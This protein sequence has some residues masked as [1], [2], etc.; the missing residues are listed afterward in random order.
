MNKS[1]VRANLL[2]ENSAFV[3]ARPRQNKPQKP[4]QQQQQQNLQFVN[5]PLAQHPTYQQDEYYQQQQREQ[6]H[7]HQQ[8][9]Q[10]H[11]NQQAP[12][13][14][15]Q[16]YPV[17]QNY[18]NNGY[19]NQGPPPQQRSHT[20]YP[21]SN[22]PTYEANSNNHP[23]QYMDKQRGS[24]S[25]PYQQNYD[26]QP[27][28]APPPQQQRSQSYQYESPQNP[29]EK[30]Q[31]HDKR[32]VSHTYSQN[33]SQYHHSHPHPHQQAPPLQPLKPK[34][35]IFLMNDDS[36]DNVNGKVVHVSK[37]ADVS[38]DNDKIQQL[39][40]KI[41]RLERVLALQQDISERSRS[42]SPNNS[43]G[44]AR[45]V[46]SPT[47]LGDDSMGTLNNS[48]NSIIS[49]DSPNNGNA[50]PLPPPPPAE[51]KSLSSSPKAS[52]FK[53]EI[54]IREQQQQQQQ[55]Q[56]QGTSDNSSDLRLSRTSLIPTEKSINEENDDDE[57]DEDD[58]DYNN[59][60]P[61][62]S[63]EELEKSGSLTY[64][65]SIY[66]TPY[67]KAGYQL[68][69]NKTPTNT[70]SDE[71]STLKQLSELEVSE[72]TSNF[73][74][75][76]TKKSNL[77]MSK[78]K[79]PT[80][81]NESEESEVST[82]PIPIPV[83]ISVPV[84][85]PAP[86]QSQQ[87][88]VPPKL[89]SKQTS[90]STSTLKGLNQTKS[91]TLD[92]LYTNNNTLYHA[93]N[94]N[95]NSTNSVE[96]IEFIKYVD[97]DSYETLSNGIIKPILPSK[98][99][100]QVEDTISKF[101]KTRERAIADYKQF[102][103]KI[104]FYWAILLLETLSKTEVI[105]KMTIDG[106]VRKNPLNF[107]KLKKQRMM[108]LT[109]AIKV[110]EKL[111]QIA[112]N[113]TRARLYLGDIY[114]GGI[115]P[116]FIERDEKLGYKL[117]YE[118]AI[119]QNDPIAY[120]RVGCCLDSG[121][122]TKQDI[123]KSIMFFEKGALLGDPSCMTQ[124]GWMYL[125]GLN[126]C[127]QDI[128][129][130]ISYYKQSYETLR[131]KTIMCGD[132]LITARSFE[133]AKCSFFTL[134]KLYQ[135]DKTSFN[136]INLNDEKVI[137]TIENLKVSNVWRNKSKSLKYY[138]ESAKLGDERSQACLGYYYA[139]GF[140]PTNEFKS[141]KES[142]NGVADSIDARKSIYWFSKSAANGHPY[143]SLG[144]A[145][146]YGSG[147]IDSNGKIILKR[148]EQQAFLWGRKAADTGELSEAEF[149]IGVCFEQGFGV[150]KNLIMAE[151]Y[152]KRSSLHGYK[153]ATSKLKRSG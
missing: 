100:V 58:G 133:D 95:S 51:M 5:H 149:M 64:S 39:E 54:E 137:E 138:L 78:R 150:E 4:S 73:P 82:P 9:P 50:P 109:T 127:I 55:R 145:R 136:L 107:K 135:T 121:I 61:P 3:Q 65:Q 93:T 142:N 37:S 83:P 143:A 11:Y 52:L 30:Y 97:D 46:V 36:E 21:N 144:L 86:T 23:S 38:L 41:Q 31:Q 62:P 103:P 56:E 49:A 59:D 25:G 12:P 99:T 10:Q 32:S 152:Y 74:K 40:E 115:H 141:D 153:K 18:N 123:S 125:G 24:Y 87:N 101:R 6:Q 8:Q 111:I 69:H 112:P 88:M 147:A 104:Q 105:S 67:E 79:I 148:D 113:D 132:S 2:D 151:N 96:H 130:S 140:F 17:N 134:A 139:Q 129:L 146:W 71:K 131:S 1:Q 102:T 119:K 44:L 90:T 116:G 14:Q 15:G 117:F 43:E 42:E 45:S 70:P 118:S 33:S 66:R 68:D 114:S 81:I 89:I 108:F 35:Q 120:Y 128:S 22:Y 85:V 53:S 34:Q 29:S 110:L 26:F 47:K 84:P 122:G 92:S 60:E 94:T 98:S 28:R 7:Q 13:P 72:N 63:Y 48:T 20:S 76:K 91:G 126:G 27:Q 75:L 124:L 19:Y 80:Q 16:Q 106:K 57:D 77:L